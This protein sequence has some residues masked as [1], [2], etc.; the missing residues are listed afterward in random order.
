MIDAMPNRSNARPLRRRFLLSLP[1]LL[2]LSAC[3]KSEVPPAFKGIDI[4]G[5][6]Y[7]RDFQLTDMAGQA[8]TLA[9]YRGK[10]TMIFFGFAQC[11]DVCPTTLQRAKEVRDQLGEQ[12]DQLQVLFITVDPERDTPE[13][14]KDYM[15]AFDPS[16]VALRGTE[17]QTKAVA[18]E[19]KV[20]YQ[21][22]PTGSSYTMDHTSFNYL[23]DRQGKIRVVLRH[24]Q[25][26][27]DY[28]SDIRRLLNEK[29]A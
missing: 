19:F 10:V 4:T 9:D 2:A 7:G 18:A 22:V 20:F 8:R 13:V 1:A 11:P 26:V 3:S 27:A 14:L 17:E 24:D 21:K 15:A 5:A 28:V 29:P 12:A 16:F 23:I 25:P 6:N